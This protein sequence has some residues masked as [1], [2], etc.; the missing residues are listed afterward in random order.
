[1]AGGFHAH[2]HLAWP[3]CLA[4]SLLLQLVHALACVGKR[5]ELGDDLALRREGRGRVFSFADVDADHGAAVRG[6]RVVL[7][8]IS[9]W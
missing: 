6:A 8:E 7:A 5:G 9:S 4:E 1:M 3:A 2:E